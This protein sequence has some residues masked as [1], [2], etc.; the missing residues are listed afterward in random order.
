L[1]RRISFFLIG[2]FFVPYLYR[3]EDMAPMTCF[4]R[5]AACVMVDYKASTLTSEAP[6][7][8]GADDLLE[9][10]RRRDGERVC[11]SQQLEGVHAALS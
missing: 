4:G 8:E 3:G 6:S 2:L 7:F 11:D 5:R 1:F 10:V 9:D